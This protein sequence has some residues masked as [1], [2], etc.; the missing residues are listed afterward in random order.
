MALRKCASV[1]LCVALVAL[2]VSYNLNSASAKQP[3]LTPIPISEQQDTC[4]GGWLRCTA[5]VIGG[6]IAGSTIVGAFV[7][8]LN[9]VCSCSE[10]LDRMFSTKF[11]E[12]C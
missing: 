6:L 11:Q 2:C 5:A 4:G 1:F 12:I 3:D 10:Y 7:G 9:I 8:S